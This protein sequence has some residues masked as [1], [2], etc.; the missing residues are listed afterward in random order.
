[1]QIHLPLVSA[2]LLLGMCIMLLADM[3]IDGYT[4]SCTGALFVTV[5]EWEQIKCPP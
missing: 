4:R 5:S 3:Y 1:M 2:T